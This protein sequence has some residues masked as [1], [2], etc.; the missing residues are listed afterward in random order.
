MGHVVV[1]VRWQRG[2]INLLI[3]ILV[4]LRWSTTCILVRVVRNVP[5]LLI[6]ALESLLARST[7]GPLLVQV[8]DIEAAAALVSAQ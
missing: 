6:P 1:V 2:V 5:H 3:E 8:L 4:L 7:Y